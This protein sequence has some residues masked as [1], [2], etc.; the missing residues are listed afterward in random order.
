M[1]YKA[2]VGNLIV[3]FS[4]IFANSAK[5]GFVFEKIEGLEF[6]KESNYPGERFEDPV[7]TKFGFHKNRNT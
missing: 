5:N 2:Q 1:R 7:L 4:S 3:T 6:D